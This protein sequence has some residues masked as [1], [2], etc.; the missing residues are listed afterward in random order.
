VL[1]KVLFEVT[2]NYRLDA[3]ENYWD[4]ECGSSVSAYNVTV[5]PLYKKSTTLKVSDDASCSA[6][7]TVIIGTAH[8]SNTRAILVIFRVN[9]LVHINDDNSV[10]YPYLN[11]YPVEQVTKMVEPGKVDMSAVPVKEQ[12]W[13]DDS[14]DGIEHFCYTAA[15]M[16]VTLLLLLHCCYYYCFY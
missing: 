4:D 9:L 3:Y 1:R 15:L 8:T 10:S 5:V 13:A 6:R 12:G 11:K 7:T 16:L 2:K 14:D